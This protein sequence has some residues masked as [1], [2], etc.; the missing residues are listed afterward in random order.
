MTESD[1]PPTRLFVATA[2]TPG[3]VG[4]LQLH[5]PGT[6]ATIEQLT[7]RPAPPPRRV[8]LRDFGGIDQ[9]LVVLGEAVG[10]CW[11]QLMPHGGPR[12]IRALADRLLAC[13]AMLADEP[14]ARA[15]YPEAASPI[16]A[17]VLLAIARSPS[18]AAIDLLAAQPRLWGGWFRAKDRKNGRAK[19]SE[20]LDFPLFRS[21]ALALL[22]APPTV[23]VVGRPNVGKSTLT[24]TLHG[25]AVSIVADLPGTTRDWVGSLVELQS[26]R[27]PARRGVAVK[28]LDTPGLRD[29][30]DAVEQRAIEVARRVIRG[31]EVLI[32]LRDPR[33]DWPEPA[34]LP[35]EPD[36]WV[37]NKCDE[38]EAQA[39]GGAAE[40]GSGR[41]H[42][43]RVSALHDH[44]VTAL[45]DA[46]LGRLGLAD[47]AADR[48]WPFSPT[49][50]RVAAG[51]PID[52]A[53][54]LGE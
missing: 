49:L 17:D 13:G 43:M 53:A 50:R 2:P 25:R 16:E 26:S 41:D 52:L 6:G 46:V 24:N 21:S 34:A 5:G 23:A 18:P 9:G 45:A 3:A 37:M 38:A 40:A 42:P 39:G 20:C 29:S 32:A 19:D 30:G 36:L 44:G 7:M 10:A 47:L 15:V 27:G 11:A 51:E 1:P 33:T 35:R 8:A 12:V 31:A 48:L 4:I 14:E 22:L 54:Y 28:W